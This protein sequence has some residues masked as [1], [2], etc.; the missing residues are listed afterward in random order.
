MHYTQRTR[1]G[2]GEA[3]AWAKK[4]GVL[5]K[6]DWDELA[7][8]GLMP[9]EIP[10]N[11]SSYYKE[12]SSW[13]NFLDNQIKGGASITEVVIGNEIGQFLD[14]DSSIRSIRLKDGKSKRVDI[15][16]PSKKL[17]IEYDGAHWHKALVKKDVVD[18]QKLNEVGWSVL[19]IRERPL[20]KISDLD[21]SVSAKDSL[22]IKASK[23]INRLIE[24]HFLTATTKITAYI[25]TGALSK[26]SIGLREQNWLSYKDAKNWAK[27]QGIK[28]ESQWRKYKL[29]GVLP[30]N[31]PASPDE[32]Y[33]TEWIGWG[34][35]LGT[36]NVA[37]RRKLM[38]FLKAREFVRTLGIKDSR[39]WRLKISEGAIP[40]E[41]ARSPQTA[42]ADW[43]SWLDWLGTEKTAKRKREWLE[44]KQAVL[45]AKSL[46]LKSEAEWRA[47]RKKGLIPEQLPSAP[48]QLYRNE[49]MGWGYWLGTGNK[50]R[51]V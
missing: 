48:D 1:V 14:V 35:F 16:I 39:D 6:V 34:A 20:K 11:I 13:A 43:V 4:M 22:F 37:S 46:G 12:W 38:P 8:T 50:K 41:I 33:R 2:Y 32:V 45:I 30:A 7:A 26:A 36:G 47:A 5:R 18:N 29:E 9:P 17:L 40:A 28:S 24:L 21:V 10:S 15:A 27:Q 49:W 44:F 19:R 3:K 51:G 42:Y 25:E 23:V 31:V